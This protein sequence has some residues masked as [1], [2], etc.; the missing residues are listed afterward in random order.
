MPATS[1]SSRPAMVWVQHSFTETKSIQPPISSRQF[2][3]SLHVAKDHQTSTSRHL[4]HRSVI[5]EFENKVEGRYIPSTSHPQRQLDPL[6]SVLLATSYPGMGR[7][8]SDENWRLPLTRGKFHKSTAACHYG[9]KSTCFSLH[10]IDA[11]ARAQARP[12]SRYA[13]SITLSQSQFLSES[14][15]NRTEH[16]SPTNQV[17]DET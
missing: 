13:T 16:T 4:R 2:P 17:I 8:S 15:S 9:L 7:E 3:P 10:K 1:Q 14:H 11:M 5:C 12:R 6:P